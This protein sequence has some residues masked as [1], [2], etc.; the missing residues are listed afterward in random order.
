MRGEDRTVS[1]AALTGQSGGSEST[2]VE[3]TRAVAEVQA[4]VTVARACP[5]DLERARDEMRRSCAERAFADRAFY[6]VAG[7]GQGPSVHLA[8]ELARVWGNIDYGVRE[9]RRDDVEG[10]SEVQAYAWDQETNTRTVRSFIVPHARTTRKGRQRLTDLGDIYLN[11]QNQGAKA[12]RE[13]I[14]AI[15]PTWLVQEA[16]D[17]CHA[18]ISGA[19]VAD[20]L[21]TAIEGAVSAFDAL[22]VNQVMLERRVG[23]PKTAWTAGS[24]APWGTPL[25]APGGGYPPPPPPPGG[26]AP[27]P[28]PPPPA[29]GEKPSPDHYRECHQRQKGHFHACAPSNHHPCGLLDRPAAFRVGRV[30]CG[31][32]PRGGRAP[33]HAVEAPARR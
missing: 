31:L 14:F 26:G 24:P 20:G 3:Q 30:R 17:L 8:R 29:R 4:A 21:E 27:P 16:Q 23:R 33:D 32:R 25:G 7:R 18:T 5:R 12:V 6:S 11:N 13:C 1:A 10:V 22:G 2:V 28:P 15:L 19:V 9:M